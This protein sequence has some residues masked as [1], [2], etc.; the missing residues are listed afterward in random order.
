MQT[1]YV[2][3]A[4]LPLCTTT[5]LLEEV[6]KLTDC[7]P[8]SPTFDPHRHRRLQVSPQSCT[9]MTQE[10]ADGLALLHVVLV[11]GSVTLCREDELCWLS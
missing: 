2:N 5:M 3:Q 7:C 8:D 9:C 6:Q 11:R 1:S 10:L 4:P